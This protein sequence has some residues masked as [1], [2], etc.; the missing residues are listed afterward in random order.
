[1]VS[2]ALCQ[3][4]NSIAVEEADHRFGGTTYN[5][6]NDF[7]EKTGSLLPVPWRPG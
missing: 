3:D 7:I 4:I 6:L 5:R 2:L 1:M